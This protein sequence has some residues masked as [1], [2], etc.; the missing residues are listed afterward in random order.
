MADQR[1]DAAGTR[2]LWQQVRR[3]QG[4]AQDSVQCATLSAEELN[5]HYAQTST[6]LDYADPLPKITVNNN[7]IFFSEY[8]VFRQLEALRNSSAGP[9]LLP[10]WFLRLS[11]PFICRPL[12]YFYN[13]FLSHSLVPAS[14]KTATITPV[15]KLHPPVKA[16]D[17]RPI[18]VTSVLSRVIEKLLVR[19]FL[20]PV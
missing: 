12:A 1:D 14:W 7:M 6:D 13:A 17:F 20:Y 10:P 8:S 11:A 16:S 5:K 2:K 4:R 19:K 15:P 9:D 18:S 3:V